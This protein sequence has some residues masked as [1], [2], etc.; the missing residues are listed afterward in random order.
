M[1]D[2]QKR[3][4]GAGV[5][6]ERP[7]KPAFCFPIYRVKER[8]AGYPSYDTSYSVGFIR[9]ALLR[10]APDPVQVHA[11]KMEAMLHPETAYAHPVCTIRAV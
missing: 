3:E 1:A 4:N 6:A 9:P 10:R 8:R 5:K 7:P 2:E 11:R